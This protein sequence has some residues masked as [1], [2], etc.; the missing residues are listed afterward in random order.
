MSTLIVIAKAPVPGRVKTRLTPPLTPEQ[1]AELAGAALADTL[2]AVAGARFSLPVL[3]LEGDPALVSVPTRFAVV[4]QAGG[5]LDRR[6]AAAFKEAAL[7]DP[8]PALLIGMDTPQVTG[9][10]LEACM[11][12][13]WE[14]ATFG[15]A[16]DGGFWSLG[17]RSPREVDLDRLLLDV[18]M[19]MDTTGAVQLGRL[20]DAGLRVRMLPVL[21]DVDTIADI[22]AVAAAA[23]ASRFAAV[24]RAAGATLPVPA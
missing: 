21:R 20:T 9:P 22:A 23:P 18:P 5:G 12:T 7:R 8:G 16:Q 11:P 1:G 19:S 24:A 14:D 4:T 3:A 17:F 15:P 2:E 6:L 13:V 10:L